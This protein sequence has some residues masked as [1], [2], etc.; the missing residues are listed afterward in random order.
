MTVSCAASSV[1][2]K[3]VTFSKAF[4]KTP[5]VVACLH[6]SFSTTSAAAKAWGDIQLTATSVSATGFT[7]QVANASTSAVN[8]AISYI[9]MVM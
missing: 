8:P 2:N 3:T 5:I 7:L 6:G 4:S 1:T 9:A